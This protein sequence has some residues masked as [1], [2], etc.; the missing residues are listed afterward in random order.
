[1]TGIVA[2]AVTNSRPVYPMIAATLLIGFLAFTSIPREADPDIQFPFV[3]ITVIHPGI[4]PEDAERLLVR[5]METQLRTIEGLKK[6][7]ATT[8]LG[9]ANIGLEF[10]VNFDSEKAIRQVR[11][12]VDM[13]KADLPEDT[14]EPIVQEASTALNPSL[15]IVLSGEIPDRL[16]FKLAERLEEKLEAL[17]TVL[18]ADVSGTRDDLLEIVIDP[19]KLPPVGS[20]ASLTFPE[21]ERAR[22][23]N[24]MEVFFA[25]R[26]AVPRSRPARGPAPRRSS[27]AATRT[28]RRRGPRRAARS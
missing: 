3:N 1:M 9:V 13:A 24:G 17:P 8:V 23:S 7:T 27:A 20:F 19:A 4:S 2:W 14:R 22:L 6:I 26:S 5:P 28:C 12:K 25:R 11:E 21:I 16:L 18:S 10:D 15:T